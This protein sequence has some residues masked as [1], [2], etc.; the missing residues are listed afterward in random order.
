VFNGRSLEWASDI[1]AL[2]QWGDDVKEAM[3]RYLWIRMFPRI[4]YDESRFVTIYNLALANV[5]GVLGEF[6]RQWK[7]WSFRK[8]RSGP[9]WKQRRMN[10][11]YWDYSL[12]D[13]GDFRPN[14]QFDILTG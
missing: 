14:L 1:D 10:G 6:N 9:G 4:P 8:E 3:D 13:P 7:D 11:E 12:P 5:N 2:A